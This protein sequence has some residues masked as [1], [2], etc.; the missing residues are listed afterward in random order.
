MA[1]FS[2]ELLQDPSLPW[3]AIRTRARS[4]KSV[5]AVLT[6]WG[7]ECWAPTAAV[8]RQWSDRVKV[9]NWPLFPGYLF[10]RVPADGWYPLLDLHGVQTVV[11]SGRR[12]AAIDSDT[13]QDIRAF[14]HGLGSIQELPEYVPWFE[15]GDLV[16]VNDGPFAGVRAVVTRLDG[17]RRVA[18]GM[19]MLGQGVS[20]TL[21]AATLSRI[22]A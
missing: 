16:L 14:A 8:R 4:E 7:M 1:W 13:L 21:P 6:H 11:K 12:A 3:I 10:A 22:P 20:V 18:V 9:V 15:P 17:Q 5:A 2:R 19:T